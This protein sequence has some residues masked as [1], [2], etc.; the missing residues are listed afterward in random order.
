[1]HSAP[2]RAEV[3]APIGTAQPRREATVADELAQPQ[4]AAAADAPHIYPLDA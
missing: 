2:P 4:A 3:E 1:M